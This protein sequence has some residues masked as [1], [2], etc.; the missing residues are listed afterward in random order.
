MGHQGAGLAHRAAHRVVDGDDPA[1]VNDLGMV[2]QL[3]ALAEHL[4]PHVGIVVEDLSPL[5]QRPGPDGGQHPLPELSATV[6]VV[7]FGGGRPIGI[8]QHPVEPQRPHEGGEQ[9]RR[10]LGEL[11]PMAVRAEGDQKPE[12]EA[13]VGDAVVAYRGCGLVGLGILA[14]YEGQEPAPRVLGGHP[15]GQRRLDALAEAGALPLVEG[16]QRAVQRGVGR[17]EGRVGNRAVGRTPSRCES[18]E[19][20]REAQLG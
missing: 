6:P 14:G 12:G 18:T 3:S 10:H 20:D 13:V 17:A 7:E 2:E 4:G 11:H 1:V 15:L 8:I 5:G 9:V 19:L 16:G